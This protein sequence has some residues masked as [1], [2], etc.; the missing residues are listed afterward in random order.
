MKT[1]T[2]MYSLA[3]TGKPNTEPFSPPD[4]GEYGIDKLPNELKR[5]LKTLMT[6]YGDDVFLSLC[7]MEK[8]EHYGYIPYQQAKQN[9]Q[10]ILL[11]EVLMIEFSHETEL[12]RQLVSRVCFQQG[13]NEQ[14]LLDQIEREKLEMQGQ[15]MAQVQ[16]M[17]KPK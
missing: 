12:S 9:F 17:P 7:L 1:P 3:I 14:A 13:I 16:T 15:G 8:A 5:P 10:K 2:A 4:Y 6:K 11:P